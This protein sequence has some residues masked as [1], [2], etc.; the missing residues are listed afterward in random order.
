[1]EV[2]QAWWGYPMRK[3][4]W[5]LFSQISPMAV[6]TPLQL[7]PRGFDRRREQIMSKNQ[8]SATCPQFAHWLVATARL[9]GRPE[10]LDSET[11][12]A[13]LPPS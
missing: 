5:L 2:W 4:T 12:L 10:S 9:A 1:M 7:H 8:R 13:N 3:A 6:T 11:A